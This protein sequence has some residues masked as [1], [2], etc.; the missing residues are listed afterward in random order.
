[1]DDIVERLKREA[2]NL[3]VTR[4]CS[5]RPSLH[6]EDCKKCK[7]IKLLWE[8]AHEIEELRSLYKAV[9]K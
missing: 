2:R 1:M 8:A 6:T 5:C 3:S 4:T 9:K 7:Q